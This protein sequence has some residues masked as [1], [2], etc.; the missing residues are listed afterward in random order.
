MAK[1]DRASVDLRSAECCFA[2][3]TFV[4]PNPPAV[5]GTCLRVRGPIHPGDT[6]DLF[7]WGE[8]TD[9]DG[10]PRA[11]DEQQIAAGA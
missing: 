7:E 11:H 2:C 1:K 4:R 9:D 8:E 3:A 6:C 10:N 5:L